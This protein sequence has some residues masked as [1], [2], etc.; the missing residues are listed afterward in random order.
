MFKLKED[1]CISR[2]HLEWDLKMYFLVENQVL[3]VRGLREP[4]NLR[5]S[6]SNNPPILVVNGDRDCGF[7]VLIRVLE[8]DFILMLRRPTD[9]NGNK[10]RSTGNNQKRCAADESSTAI[11]C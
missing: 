8:T 3:L 4:S 6:A 5:F 11:R 10:K 2:N 7:K 1:G 9:F